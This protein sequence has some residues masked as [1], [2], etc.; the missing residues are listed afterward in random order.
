MARE[1][2]RKPSMGSAQEHLCLAT[3][4]TFDQ[5]GTLLMLKT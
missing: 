5:I 4:L 1:E 2:H 3:F